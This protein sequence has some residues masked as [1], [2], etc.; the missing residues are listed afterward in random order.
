MTSEAALLL[1]I[2]AN[3]LRELSPEALPYMVIN[4]RGDRRYR[5]TD[6]DAYIEGRMKRNLK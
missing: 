1:G 3:R 6:I 2:H 5:I 4:A